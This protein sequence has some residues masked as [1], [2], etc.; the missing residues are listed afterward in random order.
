MAIDTEK[1]LSRIYEA[2]VLLNSNMFD[3][4]QAAKESK[5]VAHEVLKEL[6]LMYKGT[7]KSLQDVKKIY[8]NCFN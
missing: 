3:A 7:E 6:D 4:M 2:N 5:E 8:Q 1:T